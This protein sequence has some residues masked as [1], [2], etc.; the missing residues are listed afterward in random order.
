M[1]EAP[2]TLPA[3]TCR[4]VSKTYVR[5]SSS[6]RALIDVD[7]VA[8]TA[9]ITALFGPSGSGKSTLLRL[10]AAV[11]RPD[12]G[13]VLVG[14]T[15][16]GTL[17]SRR[18]RLLRRHQIGYVFQ[19]PS[20]NLIG[21]LNAREQLAL[22]AQL[23]GADLNDPDELLD[24]VGLGHRASHHPSQLSGGEQ[25]RLAFAA[26]VSGGPVVVLGDEPTAELDTASGARLLSS[27]VDMCEAG[28]SFVIASHDPAVREVAHVVVELDHGRVVQ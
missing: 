23:R 2:P 20:H 21:Y 9:R 26:A 10:L 6:V 5:G 16:V 27:I 12:R 22:A 19:D 24:L 25:Q 3:S 8:P 1:T 14:A 18:R 7:L 17:S 11:D 15:S 28:T 4:Q 13:E